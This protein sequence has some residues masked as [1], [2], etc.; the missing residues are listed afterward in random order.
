MSVYR[1]V[2]SPQYVAIQME[3]IHDARIIPLDGR[4]HVSSVLRS[5]LG[6]SR[7]H[8]DGDTLVV[9]TTNFHPDGNPMGGYTSLS[10]E[11]LRLIERFRRT[12]ADTLEYT[13][14][15][16]NPTMWTR[17]WT[18]VINW[19]QAKGELYEY[20]CHEGN[21][22]LPGMLTGARADEAAASR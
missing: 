22:S 13:F 17:P 12:A 21:Y 1:I 11:N 16:D 18:A 5:Y 19:K 9:E 2:Q 8:W 7:G 4:P 15:V 14:T 3:K 20:A 10:D 6:D